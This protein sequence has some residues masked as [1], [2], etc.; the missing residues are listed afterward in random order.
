[1]G[2]PILRLVRV[3]FMQMRHRTKSM[4]AAA[5]FVVAILMVASCS[6][7]SAPNQAAD[8]SS[9][10]YGRDGGV[11]DPTDEHANYVYGTHRR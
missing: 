1:M 11:D 7:A 10:E 8:V 3:L 2:Q 5:Q 9:R 4:T 6:S